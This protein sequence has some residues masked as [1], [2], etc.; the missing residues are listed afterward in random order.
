M[1]AWIRLGLYRTAKSP[2]H[3][4]DRPQTLPFTI[5]SELQ[6]VSDNR[7]DTKERSGDDY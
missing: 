4:K 7:L 2:F 6:V 5:P 3:P 1:S